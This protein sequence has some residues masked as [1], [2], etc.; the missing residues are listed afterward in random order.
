MNY[1]EI[2]K[3]LA[4]YPGEKV[5]I[6]IKYLS[7]LETAKKDG[8]LKNPWMNYKTPEDH[9]N[10]FKTVAID[11][12][13]FDGVNITLQSTGISYNYVAYK[14]KMLNVYPESIIDLML[15][16]ENDEFSFSK[17]S[18]AV[19]YTHKINNPFGQK[20][21]EIVGGYCVIKNK[22][23]EFLTILS[24]DD[25]DKHRKVAKTDFIWQKW[26]AEMALKT[27]VK[28][29]CK[30]HFSD[31]YQNI[32]T[33]DNENYDIGNSLDVPIEHKT[34]IEKITTVDELNAY[35]KA[36]SGK[37]AGIKEDFI[38]MLAER[39]DAIENGNI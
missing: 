7:D 39:K 6:Y 20:P 9:I 22:R 32:E 29:A 17:E 2:K 37:L 8:K 27:V 11:L 24:K 21:D 28:K 1:N 4:D 30:Q 23:G 3:G 36:N 14:N 31:I 15:V 5:D 33:V 12:L 10:N 34:A 18:G 26:F 25:I 38:K 19:K 13:V 16:Y 35:Y